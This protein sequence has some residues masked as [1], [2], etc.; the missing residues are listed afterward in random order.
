MLPNNFR[1]RL[2]A[3]TRVLRLQLGF[4]NRYQLGSLAISDRVRFNLP[5]LENSVDPKQDFVT[6]ASRPSFISWFRF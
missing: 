1:R 6:L 4:K 5:D 3:L 2:G